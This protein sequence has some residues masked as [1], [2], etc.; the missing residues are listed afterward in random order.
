MNVHLGTELHSFNVAVLGNRA[1]VTRDLLLPA[2]C[3]LKLHI[4]PSNLLRPE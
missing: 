1:T 4:S 3:A 2:I